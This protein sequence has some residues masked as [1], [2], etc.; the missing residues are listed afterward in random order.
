MIAIL[1]RELKAYFS[2]PIGYIFLAV[3]AAF[4]GLFF[5]ATCLSTQTSNIGAVFSSMF[6][7]VLFL[8]PI[9]TMRLLSEDRKQKTDQALLTA[10]VSLFGLVMGKF[11]AALLLFAIALSVTFLMMLVLA[12]LGTVEWAVFIANFIG[13][14]LMGAAMISIGLFISSMTENQVIAAVGG[15][16]AMLGLWLLDGVGSM[17][18][19][20][21]VQTVLTSLSISRRYGDFTMGLFDVSNV[22]FFLSIIAVFVFFT[23]RVFEKRRWS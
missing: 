18:G 12:A 21:I 9:L 14:L 3:F 16:A 1:R 20:G 10:P 17:I 13:M 4:A 2:S 15:F 5:F 22:L 11:L 8:I 19:S 7:I 6:T 23:I